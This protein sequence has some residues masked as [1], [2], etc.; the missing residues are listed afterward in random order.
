MKGLVILSGGLD[1]TTLLYHVLKDRRQEIEAVSFA[2][3]QRHE[4]RELACADFH[5]KKLGVPHTIIDLPFL[6]DISER[7]GSALVNRG[8]PVPHVR[9]VM[10]DPQPVT[11]VPN[12]N[13]LFLSIAAAQAEAI[14]AEQV[15]YGAQKHDI[16]GYWD[17]TP[18][19]LQAMNG[20]M[21]LNRKKP[22]QILAPF[23]CDSKADIVRRG[24][25][26]C[27]DYS[28]TWSCYEGK[29]QACGV[30]STCAE[31]LKGFADNDIAD[32]LSYAALPQ[33]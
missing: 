23:V 5:T 21:T 22:V 16:S 8:V 13:M 6:R 31:R 4:G 9:T 24:I 11:Y 30:C 10:G 3:G 7:A 20:V 18:S 19:F 15:Y 17:T 29:D 28:H 32:P 1:S 27:V 33:R 25:A 12:R 14:G 26:L 2:Y